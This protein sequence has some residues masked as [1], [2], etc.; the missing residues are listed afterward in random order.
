[1]LLQK[2]RSH[3]FWIAHDAFCITFERPSSDSSFTVEWMTV[4]GLHTRSPEISAT[5]ILL[6]TTTKLIILDHHRILFTVAGAQRTLMTGI[7][8]PEYDF[9]RVCHKYIE[10]DSNPFSISIFSGVAVLSC[11]DSSTASSDSSDPGSPY[12]PGSLDDLVGSQKTSAKLPSEQHIIQSSTV[13]SSCKVDV[14]MLVRGTTPLQ[15]TVPTNTKALPQP[16]ANWNGDSVPKLVPATSKTIATGNNQKKASFGNSSSKSAAKKTQ[17]VIA[18]A[19]AV[20]TTIPIMGGSPMTNQTPK[21]QSKITGFFKSQMKPTQS[22]ASNGGLVMMAASTN[23]GSMPLPPLVKKDLTNLVIRSKEFPKIQPLSTKKSNSS[24]KSGGDKK[25]R[26]NL[27]AKNTQVYTNTIKD[28]IMKKPVNIAPRVES[29]T[30]VAQPPQTHQPQLLSDQSTANMATLQRIAQQPQLVLTAFRVTPDM[31]QQNGHQVRMAGNMSNNQN[32]TTPQNGDSS[33]NGTQAMDKNSQPVPF[34]YPLNGSFVSFSNLVAQPHQLQ[35]NAEGGKTLASQQQIFLNQLGAL[36]KHTSGQFILNGT[37]IKLANQ[38]TTIEA[39][40]DQNRLLTTSSG[41]SVPKGDMGE[42]KPPPTLISTTIPTIL[43][44]SSPTKQNTVTQHNAPMFMSLG[45]N[46]Q[47]ILNTT[48]MPPLISTSQGQNVNVVNNGHQITGIQQAMPSLQPISLS[49]FAEPHVA[50]QLANGAHLIKAPLKALPKRRAVPPLVQTSSNPP[51]LVLLQ[52]IAKAMVAAAAAAGKRIGEQEKALIRPVTNASN[53]KLNNVDNGSK[54]SEMECLVVKSE[55]VR[56]SSLVEKGETI[57]STTEVVRQTTMSTT[58]TT[59][60]QTT[61]TI[62]TE[63]GKKTQT[64]SKRVV[65]E[66]LS[67]NITEVCVESIEDCKEALSTNSVTVVPPSLTSPKSLVLEKLRLKAETTMRA[68]NDEA[69]LEISTDCLD[70]A[71]RQLGVLVDQQQS[72][73]CAKSP[74][75]CQPKT[76]RFPVRSG[77]DLNGKGQRKSG[78]YVSGN[79][80]WDECN[81][82]F[83][84]SSKLLDHL[85]THHVNSQGGPFKCLWQ[86]CRVNGRE[87][88]SRRWLEGHVSSHG[89]SRTFK[90]IFEGCG[91]RFSSQVIMTC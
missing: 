9:Y 25:P 67:K 79:C 14:P 13:S 90:C 19:L 38:G 12:S 43:T 23:A 52:P 39:C 58:T 3:E 57:T 71:K 24:R 15:S 37:I 60:L 74:I 62:T 29:Q 40:N 68:Y 80:Y 82:R 56:P 42:N 86:G 59:L 33:V 32:T 17:N 44:T 22:I 54:I 48:G 36:G 55:D 69:R 21:P 81:A 50:Q 41:A 34:Q 89:G 8:N 30:P 53:S 63:A 1:M 65:S 26:S 64:N 35:A 75:L 77:A 46:G 91:Q 10:T 16:W 72:Q 31:L 84:N 49:S 83:E 18:P 76:I 47:F 4:I 27:G 61:T 45:Q 20:S 11:T 5:S 73:E 6:R 70:T 85:Q 28:I 66:E 51:E 7:N 78:G 2:K 88:C 87:S